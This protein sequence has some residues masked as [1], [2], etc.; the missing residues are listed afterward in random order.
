MKSRLS[1]AGA[2]ALLLLAAACT[3]LDPGGNAD[4]SADAGIPVVSDVA[5]PQGYSLDRSRSLVLGE[6]ESW[7]GR[8]VYTINSKPEDMVTFFRQQMPGFGWEEVSVV[9]AETSVLTFV[10]ARTGRVATVRIEAR[11]FWGARIDMVVA[12][13]PGGARRSSLEPAPPLASPRTPV[14]RQAIP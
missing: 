8:L 4:G 11:T 13:S 7:T 14:T 6:G 3:T 10:S 12:P 2:G 5:L 1:A 9:R